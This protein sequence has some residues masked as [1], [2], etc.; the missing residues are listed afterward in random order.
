MSIIFVNPSGS[1]RMPFLESII[2]HI[3]ER[4]RVQALPPKPISHEKMAE[5]NERLDKAI[6]SAKIEMKLATKPN[7]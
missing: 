2:E 1:D 5:F 6:A 4:A 3:S 7:S